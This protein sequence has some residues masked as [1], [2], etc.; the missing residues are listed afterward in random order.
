M[1]VEHLETTDS[2][3]AQFAADVRA[4][5]D[6]AGQKELPSKYLYDPIGSTLFEAI[7]LLPEYGLT[8]A[9]ERILRRHAAE[10]RGFC[11]VR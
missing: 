8:R 3:A 2:S 5:L 11:P 4:G 9:D 6:R 7:S 1:L 10:S